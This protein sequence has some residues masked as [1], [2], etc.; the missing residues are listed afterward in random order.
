MKPKYLLISVFAIIL[1][2]GCKNDKQASNSIIDTMIANKDLSNL[3]KAK[4]QIFHWNGN[5]EELGIEA[6][7]L[8]GFLADNKHPADAILVLNSVLK[9]H[10]NNSRWKENA[11]LLAKIYET[12]LQK[13]Q[14]ADIIK[15]S[16]SG[17]N[18]E[19]LKAKIA[20]IGKAVFADP[21][22]GFDRSIGYEFVTATENYALLHP[23]DED[24]PKL[25]IDASTI[26]RNLGQLT[27]TIEIFK[28]IYEKFPD[29]PKAAYAHFYEAFT[30]D[31]DMKDFDK[32]KVAY[33]FFIKNYPDH[34]FKEQAEIMLKNLG[35]SDEELLKSLGH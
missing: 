28:W 24:V 34:P 26:A 4:D 23:N 1:A 11:T 2:Y 14:Q 27:K 22:K 29:N 16:V 32:A 9:N 17:G 21:E 30:Y 6:R 13:P 19:E 31:S 10:F 15:Q 20:E 12:N 3:A 5:E 18:E 33:E 8:A 25:L 7:K 35:K